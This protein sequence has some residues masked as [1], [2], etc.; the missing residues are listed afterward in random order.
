[1]T[2]VSDSWRGTA[3]SSIFRC[4]SRVGFNACSVCVAVDLPEVALLG[5]DEADGGVLLVC[6]RGAELGTL[7]GEVFKLHT[8]RH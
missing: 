5:V 6:V 4:F 3:E 7:A 8:H 2:Y 1:M